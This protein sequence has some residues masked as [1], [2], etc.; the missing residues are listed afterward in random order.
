MQD[1]LAEAELFVTSILPRHKLLKVFAAEAGQQQFAVRSPTYVVGADVV[2]AERGRR[3][4][5]DEHRVVDLEQLELEAGHYDVVLCVNVLEH[6]RHPLTLFPVIWN[7]L[8]NDGLFVLVL[9]NVVSLKGLVTRMTPWRL[10]RWFY[11]RILGAPPERHPVSSI[12][13]VSLRPSSLL[14]HA[15][16]G[17]WKVEY[18]R[19]YEGPTQRSVRSRIGIVGWRWRLIAAFTRLVTFGALTAEE[20]G[21]IVVLSKMA[22]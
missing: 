17:G 16:T 15:S 21:I 9:P 4:D 14:T 19:L 20:T 18:F 13:S 6:V 8:K 22:G 2:Q 3:P 7:A 12:H 10:H 11:A 1:E 5:A